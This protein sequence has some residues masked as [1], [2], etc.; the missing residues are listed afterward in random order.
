[1][2]GRLPEFKVRIALRA[3][4]RGATWAEAMRLSGVSEE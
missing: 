2:P 4:A 3:V 1:M